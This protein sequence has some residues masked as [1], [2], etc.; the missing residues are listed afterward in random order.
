VHPL[1]S[2]NANPNG[3]LFLV[4]LLLTGAAGAVLVVEECKER[5][6]LAHAESFQ[7]LVGGLGFGPALD[8]SSGA[9]AFD[10]R[11]ED[12]CSMDYGPIAGGACFSSRQAGSVFFYP[13]LQH[14]FRGAE[15][16]K[17]DA[18]SP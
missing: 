12:S 16:E 1:T 4:L 3:C 18:L 2:F 15:Q 10:P 6:T 11:L 14:G 8:L 17:G 5:D 7:R 13:P 9:S